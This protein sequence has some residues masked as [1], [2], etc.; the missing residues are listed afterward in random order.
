MTTNDPIDHDTAQGDY[1]DDHQDTTAAAGYRLMTP[2]QGVDVLAAGLPGGRA[3]AEAMLGLYLQESTGEHGRPDGGWQVDDEDLAEVRQRFSWVNSADG[4]TVEQAQARAEQRAVDAVLAAEDATADPEQLQRLRDEV[5]MWGY[6]SHHTGTR[7]LTE[8]QGCDP[9]PRYVT[10]G[11]QGRELSHRDTTPTAPERE[12]DEPDDDAG[13]PD[14]QGPGADVAALDD[15]VRA[16]VL[17]VATED[18]ASTDSRFGAGH[19]AIDGSD[20]A[21]WER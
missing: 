20:V 13:R 4:E 21:G 19:D 17:S 12:P 6:R 14:T 3:D 1:K 11:R 10:L 9:V 2:A 15:R 18:D 7:E 8:Q 5:E 16:A